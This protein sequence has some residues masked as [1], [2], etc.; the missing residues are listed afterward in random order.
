MKI[1]SN[2]INDLRKCLQHNSNEQREDKI[3]KTCNQDSVFKD[4]VIT[5]ISTLNL[6]IK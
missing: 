6:V 2:V 4:S 1:L 3:N 5:C